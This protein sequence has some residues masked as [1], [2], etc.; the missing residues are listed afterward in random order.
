M[1]YF[2]LFF[3]YVMVSY[4]YTSAHT[5]S[6]ICHSHHLST[7]A[8]HTE[9]HPALGYFWSSQPLVSH[10]NSS[11]T[12]YILLWIGAVLSLSQL[13]CQSVGYLG[14]TL[15]VY[16]SSVHQLN[17]V[18]ERY[19]LNWFELDSESDT[20]KTPLSVGFCGAVGRNMY[21]GMRYIRLKF[22]FQWT[23][24]AIGG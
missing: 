11:L 1:N 2:L 22:F 6:F 19:L 5:I 16:L 21:I 7:C 12:Y 8:A 18:F 24:T 10:H 14:L 4:L 23:S 9:S 15:W 13:H 17:H 3:K 20:Y